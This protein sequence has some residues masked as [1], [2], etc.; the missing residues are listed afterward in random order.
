VYDLL[1]AVQ[2]AAD[3]QCKFPLT[4]TDLADIL[5]LS[6]VHT[7]RVVQELRRSQLISWDGAIVKIHDWAG[8]RDFCD[9]DNRYLHF[10]RE[11]R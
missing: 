7:N 11:P 3:H 4:Q 10:V 8:L 1:E 2:L 9:Y 5:G 6:V